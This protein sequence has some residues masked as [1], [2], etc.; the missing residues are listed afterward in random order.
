MKKLTDGIRAATV[1]F[2][3]GKKYSTQAVH[4]HTRY[5]HIS[6]LKVVMTINFTITSS[7]PTSKVYEFDEKKKSKT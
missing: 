7:L 1:L 3:W 6:M 5:L 2:L 4:Q